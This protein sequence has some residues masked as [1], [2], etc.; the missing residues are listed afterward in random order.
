MAAEFVD[1]LLFPHCDMHVALDGPALR[2]AVNVRTSDT[3]DPGR[4]GLADVTDRCTFEFFAPHNQVGHRFD[5]LPE[6]DPATGRVTAAT[7]GVYLFQAR[8][9]HGYIVGRLQV[10]NKIT[11]WWFGIDSITTA[12]DVG[13]A[14]SPGIAHAQPS[15]YAKFSDDA[16]GADRIGDITGHRYV[17]LT[18]DEPAKLA[19]TP[20]GRLRGLAETADPAQPT[21]ITGSFLG[22]TAKL[23]VRV[24][25]YA[26]SRPDLYPIQTPDVPH[27]DDMHNV[28]FVPEGFRDTDEDRKLFDQIVTTTVREMFDKPRHQPYAILEGSFNI[29]KAFVPSRDHYLTCGF[30]VTD[31]DFNQAM[32]IPFNGKLGSDPGSYTMQELVALV[33]LPM[34]NESRFDL[35]AIWSGQSLK[36]FDPSKVDGQ[37][38]AR[39]RAHEGVGILHARDTVFGLHL[40]RRPAD[41]FS[42]ISNPVVSRPATDT[43]SDQLK[44]FVA[45]V[46]EFYD[47]G[48]TRELTPDPR[49]NPPELHVQGQPNPGNPITRYLGGLRYAYA[50]FSAI[51]QN[52]VPE[53][54]RFKPSR[55]LVAIIAYDDVIGGTSFDGHIATAQTLDKKRTLEINYAD[56][57][58]K[59]EMRRRDPLAPVK[60]D[61]AKLVNTVAHE[62][63]HSFNLGD[64][65]EYFG[66]DGGSS[67]QTAD[68]EFDNLSVLGFLR[69]AG[70]P[71]TSRLIDAGKIK[72]L[73]LPR[74]SLSAMLLVRSRNVAAGIEVTI[75]PRYI[76]RWVQAKKEDAEVHLRNFAITPDGRQLPLSKAPGQLLTG[77]KI[78]DIDESLGTFVLTGAAAPLPEYRR[79]SAVYVPVKAGD[80]RAQVVHKKVREFLAQTKAPLN[81]DLDHVHISRDDDQPVD[82]AGFFPP[83]DST[84]TIGVFEGANEFAGGFYRSAGSCK[85]RN[86][87]GT[88]RVW[89]EITQDGGA[90]CYVCKWLI[91]NRVDPSYHAILS[92]RFYPGEL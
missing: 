5:G 73:E 65:Y 43:V 12:L 13:T 79:G 25:D 29:F 86:S 57:V 33:G 55:G 75:D 42:G 59:R 19:I 83:C 2:V 91:V 24:F 38:I 56:L 30:R 34:H 8:W 32:P 76:G 41:R 54:T 10:H 17:T 68:V 45:R 60:P 40:G 64:E 85:M 47:F 28:V 66:G 81:R 16:T 78:G 1:M 44:A 31:E 36:D 22:Q 51:G 15:I 7:P 53:V 6:I 62:F 37:L 88:P 70:E 92:G 20:Q 14:A 21:H 61:L 82:I 49:R 63:G 84:K 46:Y 52:W 72:W 3:A 71:A 39:W 69:A 23:P 74:T 87:A 11:A 18:P 90:F 35:V 26:K 48:V 9:E 50:P 27:A 4:Y 80:D 77:L 89:S 67:A 58:D